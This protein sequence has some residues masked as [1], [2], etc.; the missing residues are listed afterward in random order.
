MESTG[1]RRLCVL[2]VDDHL[3]TLMLLRR[4]VG[5]WGH[6]AMT[7]DSGQA[8]LALAK[9]FQFDLIVCDIGLPNEDGC[10]VLEKIRSSL[11]AVKAIALTGYGMPADVIRFREAGFDTIL[12]K[13]VELKN[14]ET[15]IEKIQKDLNLSAIG[16]GEPL[17]RSR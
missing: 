12:L 11:Y 5:R 15:A 1:T 8:A 14:L 6:H 13:P 4:A 3:D 17:C 16:E 7:A 2:L 9:A 10:E